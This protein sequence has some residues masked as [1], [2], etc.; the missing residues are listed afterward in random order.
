MRV[1]C[2]YHDHVIVRVIDGRGYC[3]KSINNVKFSINK[4]FKLG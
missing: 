1:S 4:Q 2:E 3:T